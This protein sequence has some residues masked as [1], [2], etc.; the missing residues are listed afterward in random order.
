MSFVKLGKVPKLEKDARADESE[1]ETVFARVIAIANE[2][3]RMLFRGALDVGALGFESGS[4]LEDVLAARSVI[5]VYR[6]GLAVAAYEV[7]DER[8]SAEPVTKK[9]K[10]Y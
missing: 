2:L 10:V 3:E 1:S 8:T 4:A 6:L 5:A 7:E 9:R